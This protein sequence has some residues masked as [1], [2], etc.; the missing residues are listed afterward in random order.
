M[1]DKIKNLIGISQSKC[2]GTIIKNIIRNFRSNVK[3]E[4]AK[5]RSFDLCYI[6]MQTQFQNMQTLNE[7]N[8]LL[9][10]YENMMKANRGSLTFQRLCR[11][12]SRYGKITRKFEKIMH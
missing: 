1:E 3:V 6:A 10:E 2:T 12:T 7:A 5:Q 9:V 8:K 4:R 11:C